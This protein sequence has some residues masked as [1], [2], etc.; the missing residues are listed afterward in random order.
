[1]VRG[2]FACS[3]TYSPPSPRRR[4]PTQAEIKAATNIQRI[5]RGGSTR[6]ALRSGRMK[7]QV[8]SQRLSA[9]ASMRPLPPNIKRR[10]LNK[11]ITRVPGSFNKR[12]APNLPINE[13][14]QQ[15]FRTIHTNALNFPVDQNYASY[16]RR[17]E[18]LGRTRH[19]NNLN[20]KR[21][22]I[23]AI[24][25]RYE[26]LQPIKN[27]PEAVVSRSPSVIRWRQRLEAN[28]K[29]KYVPRHQ[30]RLS[31]PELYAFLKTM[32][33]VYLSRVTNNAPRYS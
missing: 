23:K 11:T 24:L 3:R 8:R 14:L 5:Y 15:W 6:E 27:F 25:A 28:F 9:L 20:T 1:M 31:S 12:H 2:C 10:I 16:I 30:N 18:N 7:S 29:R 22:R 33:L 32:P 26:L 21:N 13:N 17:I 4:T 19:A